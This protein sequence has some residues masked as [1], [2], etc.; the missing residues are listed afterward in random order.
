MKAFGFL[1]KLLLIFSLVS[2]STFRTQGRGSGTIGFNG[3]IIDNYDQRSPASLRYIRK[4]FSHGVLSRIPL[5]TRTKKIFK[6]LSQN[7]ELSEKQ[8]TKLATLLKASFEKMQKDVQEF[9]EIKQMNP[10]H[11]T[12]TQ[13]KQFDYLLRT[14]QYYASLEDYQV[15]IEH[16]EQNDFR[17]FDMDDE[18]IPLQ[19]DDLAHFIGYR[20][21]SYLKRFMTASKNITSKKFLRRSKIIQKLQSRYKLLPYQAEKL[22]IITLSALNQYES[23]LKE[24]HYLVTELSAEERSR[25][26]NKVVKKLNHKFQNYLPFKKYEPTVRY[27]E[28]HDFTHFPHNYPLLKTEEETENLTEE[29]QEKKKYHVIDWE[30]V[31]KF[32]QYHESQNIAFDSDKWSPLTLDEFSH[33]TTYNNKTFFQKATNWIGRN[34]LTLAPLVF[35]PTIFPIAGTTSFVAGSYYVFSSAFKFAVGIKGINLALDAFLGNLGKI[36]TPQMMAGVTAATTNL[37][38][39]GIAL[40]QSAKGAGFATASE[41]PMGSNWINFVFLGTAMGWSLKNVAINKKIIKPGQKFT[42]RHRIQVLKSINYKAMGKQLGWAG[43]FAIN[44]ISFQYVVKPAIKNRNLAPLGFWLAVTLPMIFAYFGLKDKSLSLWKW[45]KN[46][47]KRKSEKE[48]KYL[49][50]AEQLQRD[51]ITK[52]QEYL[53]SNSDGDVNMLNSQLDS[54]MNEVDLLKEKKDK[55]SYKKLQ[56]NVKKLS[57]LLSSNDFFRN[58]LRRGMVELRPQTL[59]KFLEMNKVSLHEKTMSTQEKM[60]TWFKLLASI[61]GIITMSVL[62]DWGVED[63]KKAFGEDTILSTSIAAFFSSL[64]ELLS[65][66][67]FFAG[68]GDTDN[69]NVASSTNL[70]EPE[71]HFDSG[72]DRSGDTDGTDEANATE[73]IAASNATNILLAKAVLA[74]TVITGTFNPR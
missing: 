67:K 5:F 64:G 37:P 74:L 59:G 18:N 47:F 68:Q 32:S 2:C 63:F 65:T 33:F 40:T 25:K 72:V 46:L 20:P 21:I 48:Q 12:R 42:W 73:N 11:R 55:S 3:L 60:N 53:V 70:I 10:L 54:I 36:V 26:A 9:N 15:A 51:E 57:K 38:E 28:E 4:S 17:Y 29:E 62:L 22:A 58:E 39:A 43:L 69:N 34:K 56:K 35:I 13:Q 45:T 14:F 71:K 49:E 44:A 16:L 52:V 50:L 6:N 61:G 23:D 1:L 66:Q 31:K 8:A 41:T 24:Y 7:K 19:L 30:D 27:M